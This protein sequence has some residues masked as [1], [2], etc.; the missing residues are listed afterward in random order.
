MAHALYNL[1]RAKRQCGDGNCVETTYNAPSPSRATRPGHA[2]NARRLG[3]LTKTT[4]HATP[5]TT[6]KRVTTTLLH[7]PAA[8][9]DERRRGTV[10]VGRWWLV[11][12]DERTWRG[13][14]GLVMG[15]RVGIKDWR[16]RNTPR[17]GSHRQSP[18]RHWRVSRG[19][20]TW[21]VWLLQRHH[22]HRHRHQCTTTF[23]T[24]GM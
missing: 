18:G 24:C 9:C 16:R 23:T 6:H 10:P 3:T 20:R 8:R 5:D 13:R 1:P 4:Y 11:H 2:R 17:N 15:Y 14:H 22:H 19:R 21:R 7:R 12:G